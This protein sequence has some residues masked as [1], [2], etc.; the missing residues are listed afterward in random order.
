[1]TERL[2][3]GPVTW[4]SLKNPTSTEIESLVVEC[5]VPPFL[6]TDL[7]TP[8][9]Q[10]GAE[11]SEDAIKLVLDFPIVKQRSENRSKEIKFIITKDHLITI[12]YEEM[13]AVDRF[14][15]SFETRATLK[16]STH[17]KNGLELFYELLTALYV[18]ATNKLDYIETLLNDIEMRI[19]EGDEK[20][21]VIN[22][23]HASKKLISFRHTLRRHEIVFLEV[24][25]FIEAVFKKTSLAE[26]EMIHQRY[27][28]VLRRSRSLYEILVA[29]R[30]T[31][32][33]MLTTKQNEI[34]KT[35]TIMA[36]ITFPLTLF[37]QMFGM[38]T[39]TTPLIGMPGDFWIIVGIM[40]VAT[41]I[42]FAYFKHKKWM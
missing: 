38:N 28:Q 23:S 3:H 11:R 31:N 2:S 36:F 35:L 26:L 30:D 40:T 9:P 39:E 42:F 7:G 24:R 34:M 6:T 37:T 8:V 14:K 20:Q 12:Q 25:P 16:K 4:L 1:M 32:L 18:G 13:G 10:N 22:I 21:M 5:G 41:L 17:A 29:L 15:R 27:E 33:A 19:F